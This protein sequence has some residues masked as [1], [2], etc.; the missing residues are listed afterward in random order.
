MVCNNGNVR[1]GIL[2]LIPTNFPPILNNHLAIVMICEAEFGVSEPHE[3]GADTQFSFSCFRVG[4]ANLIQGTTVCIRHVE[5]LD[6]MTIVGSTS[7][8]F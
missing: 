6:G 5:A 4:A 7:Q 1:L 3:R 2:I 8:A